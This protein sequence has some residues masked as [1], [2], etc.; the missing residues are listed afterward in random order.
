MENKTTRTNVSHAAAMLDRWKGRRPLQKDNMRAACVHAMLP[1]SPHRCRRA[2]WWPFSRRVF[3][4][5]AG[6]ASEKHNERLVIRSP[7]CQVHGGRCCQ[8]PSRCTPSTYSCYVRVLHAGAVAGL[9]DPRTEAAGG[10]RTQNQCCH[11]T[12]WLTHP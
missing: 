2:R 10:G 7:S 1:S 5:C 3:K 9:S 4:L 11:G 8:E 6:Y 12:E